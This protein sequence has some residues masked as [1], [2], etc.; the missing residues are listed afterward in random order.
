MSSDAGMVQ[1]RPGVA[2][3]DLPRGEEQARVGWA[4]AARREGPADRE[5]GEGIGR[6]T[7][8]SGSLGGTDCAEERGAHLLVDLIS[9]TPSSGGRGRARS[10][11]FSRPMRIDDD[12]EQEGAAGSKMT[13]PM[14]TAAYASS[15]A[16]SLV[17]FIDSCPSCPPWPI[18]C[19][20]SFFLSTGLQ[21]DEA[22]RRLGSCTARGGVAVHGLTRLG[23]RQVLVSQERGQGGQQLRLTCPAFASENT[24]P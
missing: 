18:S 6:G 10:S 8:G 21:V 5:Q 20:A 7:R 22:Q 16:D 13:T 12:D 11:P 15:S 14:T 4:Y 2:E 1:I 9:E 3:Y 19:F 24:P 23:G 17:M